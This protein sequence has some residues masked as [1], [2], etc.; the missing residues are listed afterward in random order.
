MRAINCTNGVRLDAARAALRRG[1][2]SHPLL[3]IALAA[4][5]GVL[6]ADGHWVA[7][8]LIAAVVALALHGRGLRMAAVAAALVA[9]GH[10]GWKLSS[11]N[12][13]RAEVEEAG[14]IPARVT[15]RVIAEPRE[16]ANGWSALVSLRDGGEG[17][18]WWRARGAAPG[19]G[20]IVAASGNFQPLPQ[21][22]NPGEFDV[23]DWLF[24][25][26][27]WGV[28]ETHGAAAVVEPPAAFQ[29]W[30]KRVRDGFR[31]AVTDGLDP[32]GREAAV[33][34]AM[35]LGDMPDDQDA[36]IE[37][38]RLSGTLHVFSVSGLHVAMVGMIVWCVLRMLRVPRRPAILVI[39]V[40][41]LG[42]VW[43]TGT[44]P[45]AVRS[46][47]MATVVLA[48]FLFRRRP[49]LLNAL[50]V[51]LLIAMVA[52]GHLLFQVG[53]QLSFGVMAAIGM[54]AG[55]MSRGFAWMKRPEPYL[56]RL[57]YGPWRRRWMWCR[58]WLVSA[59]GASSAASVGS[60][61]L[62]LWHFGFAS[63][64]SVLA[65]PLIGIPVFFLMALALL[66]AGLSPLPEAR[67]AV[68]RVNGWMAQACTGV[69]TGFARVPGGHG[70]VA[71]DRPG[72]RFLVVYDVGAGGAACLFDAGTAVL[73]DT[74]SARGFE[75]SVLPS[76][77]HFAVRPRSVV[78]S[79]PDGGHLGGAADALDALPVRQILTPVERARS[80]GFRNVAEAARARDVAMV[81]GRKGTAYR[82]SADAWL[83]VLYEP[84]PWNLGVVADER[85]MV[86]RLHWRGWRVLFTADAGLATERALLDQGGDL[87]ADLV[88][89]G[90]PGRDASLGDDFLAAVR[91]MAIVASHADFPADQRV[92]GRWQAACERR[93][94]RV[95]H[96]GRTGAV[97]LV[98]EKDGALSIRGFLD[99]S[100]LRLHR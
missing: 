20:A 39:L 14:R 18:V 52:D 9:G 67:V 57:L 75:Y 99:G 64:I 86:T 16:S 21:R 53:V 68:N 94:I 36:M 17:K 50:G 33:I 79:H 60:L 8:G 48:A 97:T 73:F 3:W 2:E 84:D 42:Y 41:M 82:I 11:Q 26:G 15:G 34:R 47:T 45:P 44:K 90:R 1:V 100:D 32:V 65:S 38:Y 22:R 10:F 80:P 77:R 92:P 81:R 62:T 98:A 61:P 87:R 23:A 27:V 66:A 29:Q 54:A 74:G 51:A 56:P 55:W 96:Q 83:E 72:D 78:L 70:T 63:W 93:G 59:M 88:V 37:A 7:G 5:A 6:V 35:V 24:R 4:V 46:L 40:A 76:L 69:A 85:V 58:E 89:A 12:A 31:D 43:I 49:D 13:L 25:M 28:F 19:K 30:G 95:F 71:R 91:P